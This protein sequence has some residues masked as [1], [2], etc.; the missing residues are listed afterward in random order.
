[1]GFKDLVWVIRLLS[2]TFGGLLLFFCFPRQRRF[3]LLSMSIL[4]GILILGKTWIA[5]ACFC[6][7]WW[8]LLKFSDRLNS[9]KAKKVICW[10][11]LLASAAY[12]GLMNAYR[13]GLKLPNT[14]QELGLSFLYLRVIHVTVDWR[15]KKIADH[16]LF[17]FL[18]YLFYFPTL[19]WGPL[20]RHSSFYQTP[21]FLSDN[22]WRPYIDRYVPLRILGGI[23]KLF[24]SSTLLSLDYSTLWN[25]TATLPY[26][27]L[28]KIM[29]LRAITFYLISSGCNDITLMFSK[30]LQIP[31]GENYNYPYFRRNLAQFWRNWHISFSTI[32]RDYIYEPLGGKRKHQRLNYILTFFFCAMWHVTS[33]AF[34]IWGF[35]HGF[36]MIILREWQTFWKSGAEKIPDI[37]KLANWLRGYPRLSWTFGC[38]VTF[39]FV[40]LS[41]LPFWGGHPQGTTALLRL[42]GLDF[43]MKP[44]LR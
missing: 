4:F 38:I 34:L 23:T 35:M 40:A 32:L 29:Y 33:P 3:L 25:Q 31:L 8:R 12:F 39:H 2:F 28:L 30:F 14:V 9:E 42:L 43:I 21:F 16:S 44:F 26:L 19:V 15:G 27:T 13:I 1:M 17:N 18:L 7:V 22:N 6:L 11:I 10:S 20:E 24:V 36:G 41:W 37:G 5:V